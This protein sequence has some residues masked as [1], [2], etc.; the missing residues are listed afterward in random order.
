MCLNVDER[1]W[2]S[3]FLQPV[4]RFEGRHSDLHSS[5]L[6]TQIHEQSCEHETLD[7][8]SG[9][10]FSEGDEV[11]PDEL[12]SRKGMGVLEKCMLTMGT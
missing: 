8:Q 1:C 6:K 4:T 3:R 10:S 7:H 12:D 2:E 11:Q 9:H 5:L